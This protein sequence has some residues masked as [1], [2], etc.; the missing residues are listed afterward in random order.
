ML[1]VIVPTRNRAA[2]LELALRSLAQQTLRPSNCEIIVVDNGSRDRTQAVAGD[3]EGTF[4]SIRYI[5]D[6]S[7][8]LHVGR[9]NGFQAAK[10]DILV[11]IDDDVEAFPTLLSSIEEAFGNHKIALVGGKCLPKHDGQVPE[12]LSAMWAPNSRAER[13]IGYLSLIDLGDLPKMIDPLC[14]FGCNFSIRRSVLLAAGG[15]HPDAFPEKLIRFRGDGETYVSRYIA[16]KGYNAYYH[17]EASVYHHVPRNRM[18]LEY[19]CQRAYNEGISNSYARI[20]T[21]HGLDGD[22]RS[23]GGRAESCGSD[24]LWARVRSKELREIV[25]AMRNRV[26]RLINIQSDSTAHKVGSPQAEYLEAIA[27]AYEAGFAF[28][29]KAVRESTMLLA[30]VLRPDYWEAQVPGEDFL[31][32]GGHARSGD[33]QPDTWNLDP[34]SAAAPTARWA[35]PTSRS[36][37]GPSH[38]P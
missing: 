35:P 23:S 21:A 6:A 1:S 11:F 8:G 25:A 10:G 37:R 20:R 2:R 22:V 28:H 4:G 29:Q 5:Y 16:A 18:T 24:N 30:W 36:L 32:C 13:I 9:H 15:F 34:N 27:A 31:R 26:K 7:P 19:L 17:P 38:E 3:F 12:W 14:V 33:C